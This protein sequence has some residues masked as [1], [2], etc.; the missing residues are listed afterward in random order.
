[1]R[2]GWTNFHPGGYFVSSQLSHLSPLPVQCCLQIL[3]Y[4]LHSPFFPPE[5]NIPSSSVFFTLSSS[6]FLCIFFSPLSLSVLPSL[7]SHPPPNLPTPST[8]PSHPHPSTF[9]NTGQHIWF[10]TKCVHSNISINWVGEALTLITAT[11]LCFRHV[12]G[13]MDYY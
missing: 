2:A 6:N 4:H 11:T 1:M 10:Q 3:L 12:G 8:L 13:I 7:L 5:K 9:L